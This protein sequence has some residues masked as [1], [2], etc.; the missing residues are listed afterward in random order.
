MSRKH[1]LAP[2]VG[3]LVLAVPA[4]AQDYQPG[5][6]ALPPEPPANSAP[7]LIIPAKDTDGAYLTP[8]HAV[9]PAEAIWHV[10]SALNVAALGCRDANEAHTIAAYNALLNTKGATLAAADV[11]VRARC[12][13][14]FGAGWQNRH[15]SSMTRVYN[16]FSQPPAH[17]DFCAVAEQVLDEAQDV[18][19]ESFADFAAAALVRLEAPFTAFYRQYDSY[20]VALAN[21][22]GGSSSMGQVAVA[23]SAP[24]STSSAVELPRR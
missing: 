15:D 10:R 20:R 6:E 16:F 5:R 4:A 14:R 22:Q 21:W 8:N 13:A 7:N 11:Q 2:L 12:R 24:V 1:Y 17:A 23:V 19:A 3:A 18:P 9:S